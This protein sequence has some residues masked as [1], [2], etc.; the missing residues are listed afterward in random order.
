LATEF[1]LAQKGA[2][3]I[4]TAVDH[5]IVTFEQRRQGAYLPKLAIAT[6][7]VWSQDLIG[8]IKMQLPLNLFDMHQ[9]TKGGRFSAWP[10]TIW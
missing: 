6:V 4:R 9:Q 3:G 7:F 1:T 5:L 10:Q 2:V 8:M